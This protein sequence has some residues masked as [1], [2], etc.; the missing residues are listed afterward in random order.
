MTTNIEDIKSKLSN[1]RQCGQGWSARCPAHEDRNNSLSLSIGETGNILFKC[2]A[3]CAISAILTAL[4]LQ[5]SDLFPRKQ[6]GHTALERTLTIQHP[7]GCSLL[8]YSKAKGLP[9]KFLKELKVSE[10]KYRGALRISIPYLGLLQIV[11]TRRYQGGK[12]KPAG[13][14]RRAGVD[15][16]V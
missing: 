16:R 1:L 7:V 9:V 4:E 8:Q 2:H 11:E 6:N 3:G 5:A 10:L 14:G 15:G 12:S 13:G